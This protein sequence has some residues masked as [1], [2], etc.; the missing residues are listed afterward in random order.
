MEVFMK[1]LVTLSKFTLLAALAAS[2]LALAGK[3]QLE[4]P[5][6]SASK[7]ICAT[8]I[9]EQEQTQI[10]AYE[11]YGLT[12]LHFNAATGNLEAIENLLSQGTPIDSIAIFGLTPLIFAVTNN[13]KA[14]TACLLSNRANPNLA[15][16]NKEE[17]YAGWSAL[18]FA[19]SAGNPNLVQILIQFSADVTMQDSQDRTAADIAAQAGH[20][21][22]VN[23]LRDEAAEQQQPNQ[24]LGHSH[25]F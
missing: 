14:A 17:Q 15:L 3:R 11:Q 4:D 24:E 7:R 13:N 8:P 20:Q 10:Q 12:A 16:N 22:I 5:E 23:L 25:Y 2:S 19:A 6:D 21:G 1:K 18:H 9:D